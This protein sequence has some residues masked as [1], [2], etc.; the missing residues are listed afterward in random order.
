MY[1]GCEDFSRRCRLAALRHVPTRFVDLFAQRDRA[2]ALDHLL[3]VASQHL[4]VQSADHLRQR[5]LL[6]VERGQAEPTV[7]RG[8]GRVDQADGREL[9]AVGVRRLLVAAAVEVGAD[10]VGVEFLIDG[11][12]SIG[13][14][15][16]V[17]ER[18]R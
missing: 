1:I 12:V 2:R 14:I 10:L 4:G 16:V 3:Q 15:G 8:V 18:R 5:A 6:F 17:F 13:W 7:S 9:P 11:C